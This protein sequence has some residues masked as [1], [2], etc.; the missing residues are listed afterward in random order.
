MQLCSRI[1]GFHKAVLAF[2]EHNKITLRACL[3]C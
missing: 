2:V 1:Y 3:F